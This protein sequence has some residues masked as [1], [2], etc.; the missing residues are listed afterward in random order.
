MHLASLAY[1]FL[2]RK[3]YRNMKVLTEGIPG[4]AQKRYPLEGPRT[5]AIQHR[6]YPQAVL[7]CERRL[8]GLEPRAAIAGHEL[9][10][11]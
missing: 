5:G 3:G 1:K 8:A 7:D 2:E 11:E 6:P 10:S 4:W 9:G